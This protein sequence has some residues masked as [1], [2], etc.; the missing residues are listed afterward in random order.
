M[1]DDMTGGRPIACMQRPPP[2]G[3]APAYGAPLGGAAPAYNAPPVYGAPTGGGYTPQPA[4]GS[5]AG[6]QQA[7]PQA[8]WNAQAAAGQA[9][10]YLA[11]GGYG[12]G[13]F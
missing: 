7:Q 4:Y 5:A 10:P 12:G 9:A 11:T 3:G 1:I 13:G 8:G 2:K 6:T